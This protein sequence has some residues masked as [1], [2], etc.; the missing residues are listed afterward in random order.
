MTKI[1]LI[2]VVIVLATGLCLHYNHKANFATNAFENAV[3]NSQCITTMIK[4]PANAINCV[5]GTDKMVTDY[6]VLFP[7]K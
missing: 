5:T 6:K 2:I 7:K 1:W 3:E 4:D